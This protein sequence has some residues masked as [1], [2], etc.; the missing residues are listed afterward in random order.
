MKKKVHN[1]KEVFIL[2]VIILIGLR[3]TIGGV[4]AFIQQRRA[5]DFAEVGIEE[6][7]EGRYVAG[8][9]DS[10]LVK[11]L[12]AL[13]HD[14]YS[15]VSQVFL[16][17][18]EE[19]HFYTI[20]I[21]E[22]YYIRLMVSDREIMNQLEQFSMGIGEG[23]YIEGQLAASQASIDYDWYQDMEQFANGNTDKI[24]GEFVIREISFREKMNQLYP[25]VFI[26]L[27]AFLYYREK[28]R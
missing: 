28:I 9:V 22:D 2:F 10:Y 12:V 27:C 17:G 26:L 25:G 3:W 1:A 18:G 16:L 6:C 7:R 15:G 24:I 20:P 21:K 19:C 13:N 11:R 4:N 8:Y 5:L 14:F 23:V